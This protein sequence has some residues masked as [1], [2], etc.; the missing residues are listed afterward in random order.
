MAQLLLLF[1]LLASPIA[2]QGNATSNPAISFTQASGYS[3]AS[4][5]NSAQP[6]AFTRTDFSPNELAS[7]WALVGPIATGPVTSTVSPTPEPTAYAQ[8]DGE[9]YHRLVGSGYPETKDLKLP[10]G[11]KWGLSSSAYQIEGAAKDEGKGPS[12]WDL[13]SHRVPNFV[14]DNSTGDVVASQYY[15]YKQDFARLKGLGIPG[16]S[17]NRHASVSG[18]KH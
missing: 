7:L 10:A 15:L 11:F 16:T 5:N 1:G 2:A 6:T 12:I 9:F 18:S 14:I 8:P 3:T 13:L 17:S 4:F